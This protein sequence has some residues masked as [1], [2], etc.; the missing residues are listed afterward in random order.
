MVQPGR[1]IGN[2]FADFLRRI[3]AFAAV[4]Q[5]QRQHRRQALFG[6]QSLGADQILVQHAHIHH[7]AHGHERVNA[8]LEFQ[9]QIHI[10][11]F[12]APTHPPDD[13]VLAF[14]QVVG[15]ITATDFFQAC[16]IQPG[17]PV[18]THKT[19]Q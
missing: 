6:G 9:Q 1:R 12:L 16:E 10:K 19:P 7:D 17:N 15:D 14:A 3:P 13:I 11:P 2:Q 18:L 8:G 4:V 5:H